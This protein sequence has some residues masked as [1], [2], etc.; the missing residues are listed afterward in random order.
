[1]SD[2]VAMAHDPDAWPQWPAL[3]IKRGS[4]TGIL[5]AVDEKRNTVFLINLFSM[6]MG[7]AKLEDAEQI[8]YHSLEEIFNDGWRVD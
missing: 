7:Q 3:P 6:A 2:D 5:L 4:E 1:M 8:E